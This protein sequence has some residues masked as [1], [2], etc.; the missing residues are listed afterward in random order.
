MKIELKIAEKEDINKIAAIYSEEFSK[1]P[2]NE[3]WTIEKAIYKINLFKKY[4]DVFK[5]I[6]D[7][8]LV[9]F[10]VINTN[11]WCPGEFIF[12][13]EMA[14]KQEFQGKGIGTQVFNYLFNY[15]KEK[16]YKKFIGIANKKGKALD[17]YRKLEIK[18]NS[19]NIVIEKDL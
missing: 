11:H 5:I 1:P 17:L 3:P 6:K 12:G 13:E 15:Y 2:F 10:I 19:E 9:G 16:G 8:E 7:N 14:I 4:C 18:E